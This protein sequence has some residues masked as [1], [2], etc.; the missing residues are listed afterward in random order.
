MEGIFNDLVAFI[1]DQCACSEVPIT[2]DSAIE[3]DLGITGADGEELIVKF[4]SRYK[5][6]IDNFYFTKY[7][8]PEPFVSRMPDK[9]EV[10]TVGHLLKAIAVGRLDDSVING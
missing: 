4:S 10:L 7:F 5:I 8:Y 9:I 1:Y 2:L 6:N 3:D